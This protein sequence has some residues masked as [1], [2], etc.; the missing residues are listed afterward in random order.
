M[1]SVETVLL[2]LLVSF[3]SSCKSNQTKDHSEWFSAFLGNLCALGLNR[4]KHLNMSPSAQQNVWQF[5]KFHYWAA[6]NDSF[7]YQL[8]CFLFSRS[9]SQV[10]WAIK[11]KKIV[12]SVINLCLVW[13]TSQRYS[14][15]C[16]RRKL[17]ISYWIKKN[18]RS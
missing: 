2:V 13:P 3:S 15:Y 5:L 12:K 11:C 1:L 6:T 16:R 14:V 17:W 18:L 7:Y 9:I 10:I 4:T 8:N